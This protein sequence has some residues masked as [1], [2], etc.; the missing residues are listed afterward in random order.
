M[1]IL[2]FAFARADFAENRFH[3]ALTRENLKNSPAVDLAK[4]VSRQYEQSWSSTTAGH[5]DVVVALV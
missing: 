4:P 3:V 5:C 2:P 1:L